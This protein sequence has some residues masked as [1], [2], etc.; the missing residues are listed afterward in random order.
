MSKNKRSIRRA[1]KS[2]DQLP[3][4]PLRMPPPYWRSGGASFQLTDALTTL[5][6]LLEH[7]PELNK[8]TSVALEPHFDKFPSLRASQTDEAMEEFTDICDELW[9]LE[10]RIT[11]KAQLVILMTAI[12][13][14]E[15][16]NQFCVFNLPREFVETLER[17]SPA[18]KL[19]AAASALGRRRV[20]ATPAY[21]AVSQL[22]AWRNAFAHGHCVDRPLKSLRHNHLISPPEYPGV[23]DSIAS[24]L[25]LTAGY[26]RLVDYVRRISKNPYTRAADH[27][28]QEACASLRTVGRYRFTG[29]PT[30]YEVSLGS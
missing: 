12:Q 24:M 30:A 29:G 7:L 9:E 8:R 22:M 20:R 4:D 5:V 11:L 23:P 15:R 1:P 26:T 6:G 18:E 13:A 14:E 17:L 21:G 16:I 27:D 25:K 19:T 28:W 10:H 3:V 2:V